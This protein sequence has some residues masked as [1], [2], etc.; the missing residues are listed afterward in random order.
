MIAEISKKE[1]E[2]LG[3]FT[4]IVGHLG[5]G[6]FHE[7]I[8]VNKKDPIEFAA[9]E[10][11]VHNMVDRALE[12]EGTCTVSSS[13]LEGLPAILILSQGEHAVGMSKKSA[14]LQE[15]GNDTLAVMKSLKQALD[16]YWLMNPGKIFDTPQ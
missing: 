6:N 2:A 10:K 7:A 4:S 9:V 13:F 16:P 12:M 15:V 8:M 11:A 5:D 14:L 1:G 3:I